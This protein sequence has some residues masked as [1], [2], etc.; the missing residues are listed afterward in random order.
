MTNEVVNILNTFIGAFV[1]IVAAWG[2]SQF[3]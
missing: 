2:W 1:A 3:I